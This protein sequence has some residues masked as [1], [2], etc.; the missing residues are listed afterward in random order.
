MHGIYVMGDARLHL[1]YNTAKLRGC[2]ATAAALKKEID[3]REAL[4]IKPFGI[5][6][7]A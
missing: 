2:K 7:T 3:R 1:T 5:E 4:T 6:L